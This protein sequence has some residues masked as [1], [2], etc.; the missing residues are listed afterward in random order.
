MDPVSHKELAKESI[1]PLFFNFVAEVL[2]RMVIST[3]NH[4]L[5]TGLIDN[6]I[7][8]DIAILQ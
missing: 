2:T 7:T 3:Q 6:L 4:C 8:H 5:V 1:Y